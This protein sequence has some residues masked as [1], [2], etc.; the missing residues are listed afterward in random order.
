MPIEANSHAPAPRERQHTQHV[1]AL[2][3]L[4]NA[5]DAGTNRGMVALMWSNEKKN[6]TCYKGASV[7][8]H[9]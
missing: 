7:P 3:R 5:A 8:P 1:E 4:W 2:E 6:E 9:D